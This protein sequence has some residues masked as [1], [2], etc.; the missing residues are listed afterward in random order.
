MIGMQTVLVLC[1]R[2]EKQAKIF[3]RQKGHLL[4]HLLFLLFRIVVIILAQ[5]R[6]IEKCWKKYKVQGFHEEVNENVKKLCHFH[7]HCKEKHKYFVYTCKGHPFI[8]KRMDGM[9]HKC[10]CKVVGSNEIRNFCVQ[11]K[12]LIN[13][14]WYQ[15]CMRI[16][17]KN[18]QPHLMP[19]D[20]FLKNEM[21]FCEPYL[22]FLIKKLISVGKIYV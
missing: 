19:L 6:S 22:F 7:C 1:Q 20:D 21:P 10:T 2:P 9:Q 13:F 4:I 17:P 3:C 8:N 15:I 12:Y 11:V 16:I 5:T 14:R 18:I